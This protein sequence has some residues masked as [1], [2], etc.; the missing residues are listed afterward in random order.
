MTVKNAPSLRRVSGLS[1]AGTH[2][3][4]GCPFAGNCAPVIHVQLHGGLGNQMFQAAAGLALAA[5]HQAGLAFDLSRF[6]AQGLRAY[7]LAP[8]GLKAETLPQKP[9]VTAEIRRAFQRIT[10]GKDRPPGFAG[11]FYREPHFHVDPAFEQLPDGVMIA[12]YFQSP[13]YF[14]QNAGFVASAFA[15][16]KL[17]GP[18]A[19]ALAD[20]L[21]GENSIALHLRRDH[22]VQH[23]LDV[24]HGPPQLPLRTPQMVVG[25]HQPHRPEAIHGVLGWDYYDR[26]VEQVRTH[27][28]DARVFV[29]SD[30]PAA[31]AEGAARWANSEVM[32]GESA[33]DDFFLMSRARH[34]IIANSSFSWWSAWLDQRPGGIRIA[35]RN[36][37]AA[38]SRHDTRDLCPADWLRL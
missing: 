13:R 28:P 22:G 38:G 10:G 18:R 23:E 20:A 36:W 12:G 2:G 14:A 5:R 37:F 9:G 4:Y 21:D 19:L 8:F 11:R 3:A 33:G 31:A 6:R 30:N 1:K 24:R 29:F 34:H 17:A 32:A 35:P 25:G 27:H 7:A 26:A 16:E 15:P